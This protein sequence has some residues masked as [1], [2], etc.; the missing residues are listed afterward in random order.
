MVFISK[1][2]PKARSDNHNNIIINRSSEFNCA[3][4]NG[5]KSG[6]KWSMFAVD[7]IILLL[8]SLVFAFLDALD[9]ALCIEYR[10]IDYLLEGECI[11]CYCYSA[12]ETG[13][14][15]KSKNLSETLYSR[16]N[17]V[18]DLM[19][20]SLSWIKAVTKFWPKNKLSL[21]LDSEKVGDNK[22]GTKCKLPVGPRW[23]DCSCQ[24]CISWDSID[25]EKLYVRLGGQGFKTVALGSSLINLDSD[26]VFI[27]GF[28]SSSSFWTETIYPTLS[29]TAK[30]TFRLFAVDLLGFGKSPKPSNCRYTVAEHIDMIERSV[31]QPYQVK[32]FH[33]VAHSMG[34]IIALALAAKYP[35]AL[36]SLTLLSPPYFPAPSGHAANHFVLKKVAPRKIWPLIAFGSSVMSWYEHVGRTVCL[37]VC[38]N[39]R[40]WEWIMKQ[41]TRNRKLSHQLEDFTRHTH[42]SAW[43][44]FHNVICGAAPEID[45]YLKIIEE[46]ECKL[47][48]LHGRKDDLVPTECSLAIKLKV[49]RAEVKLVDNADHNTIIVGRERQFAR[50][51][52]ELWGSCS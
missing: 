34:C 14:S 36:K 19:V 11:P 15:R 37:I 48:V 9:L 21:N 24:A 26:V 29:E 23:S 2:C 31:L 5:G 38:K 33:L 50:E 8:S 4:H 51:L 12:S 43:H 6:R 28:L 18:R 42:C 52:E 45:K 39:H 44:C 17:F 10:C 22:A 47:M 7:A 35:N 40:L 46:S 27:H 1:M 20:A 3:V 16:K 25:R 32:S 49:S 13:G 30:S 41:L